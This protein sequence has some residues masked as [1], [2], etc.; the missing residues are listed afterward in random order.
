[1]S[2]AQVLNK[3]QQ[4]EFG[5]STRVFCHRGFEADGPDTITCQANRT[6]S[7]PPTCAGKSLHECLPGMAIRVSSAMRRGVSAILTWNE[8]QFQ[9]KV[10]LT[11]SKTADID[12]CEQGSGECT[13][14]S[15]TCMNLDGGHECRCKAGYTPQLSQFYQFLTSFLVVIAL[16]FMWWMR[17]LLNL[18]GFDSAIK[19]PS[20]KNALSSLLMWLWS[21]WQPQTGI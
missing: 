1:M 10:S 6:W 11:I 9:T 18:R 16:R 20:T 3:G 2:H 7:E 4:Y 19:P 14:A 17:K 12:E 8:N 21:N 15:T 13:K 5:E